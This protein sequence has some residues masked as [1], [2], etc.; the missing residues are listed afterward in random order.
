MHNLTLLVFLDILPEAIIDIKRKFMKHLL[1]FSIGLISLISSYYLNVESMKKS[2]K[3]IYSFLSS[4]S[5]GKIYG[6]LEEYLSLQ[7][8]NLSFLSVSNIVA[9]DE[10]GENL[11]S[12]KKN[13]SYTF[14]RSNEINYSSSHLLINIKNSDMPIRISKIKYSMSDS[15]WVYYL[16][17]FLINVLLVVFLLV[18]KKR[19]NATEH[20]YIEDKFL[21][22]LASVSTISEFCNLNYSE[23]RK[24]QDKVMQIYFDNDKRL[25]WKIETLEAELSLLES[26]RNSGSFL[27]ESEEESIKKSRAE[28]VKSIYTLTVLCERLSE[29]GLDK[30]DRVLIDAIKSSA[31][32]CNSVMSISEILKS[33]NSTHQST[34]LNVI[35]EIN[36][37]IS[38]CH[39][40]SLKK[41]ISLNY[42]PN[43][44]LC[45][46]KH[47]Y[48]KSISFIL[49][50]LLKEM[51]YLTS[52]NS[53]IDIRTIMTE[54][55]DLDHIQFKFSVIGGNNEIVNNK[56]LRFGLIK[57]ISEKYGDYFSISSIKNDFDGTFDTEIIYET[58]CHMS[59]FK[60]KVIEI[61]KDASIAV[62][63]K[64]I[65]N[66][67]RISSQIRSLGYKVDEINSLK[68]IK[69]YSLIFISDYSIDKK[70]HL[71]L[72][73]RG[74]D[75]CSIEREI[76]D[77]LMKIKKNS[78]GISFV[79]SYC[80]SLIDYK[81]VIEDSRAN[82]KNDFSS[83][84]SDIGIEKN[85]LPDAIRELLGTTRKLDKITILSNDFSFKSSLSA[86]LESSDIFE[87]I[88]LSIDSVSKIDLL[89]ENSVDIIIIEDDFLIEGSK[90]DVNNF[91]EKL[92]YN[93]FVIGLCED[94]S[95]E[96]DIYDNTVY[97]K[98]NNLINEIT[99][100]AETRTAGIKNGGNVV[101]INFTRK[102]I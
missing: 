60:S 47:G 96:D 5:D 12:G 39:E 98:S 14:I 38:S 68:D 58:K 33:E 88:D 50:F 62:Y 57:S 92:N 7:I 20:T 66:S 70:D 59:L 86:I 43:E 85:I 41:D 87:F 1:L 23:L 102:N 78:L 95:S 44:N 46:E 18:Y 25:S 67:K 63:D 90:L 91:K 64:D 71:Y 21:D 54:K 9:F 79:L 94:S 6:S 76:S 48:G 15:G 81:E 83:Y 55:N 101:N 51:I 93:C 52:N 4:S 34:N 26:Q 28:L 17:S 89:K 56:K 75:I 22:N 42:Y 8:N 99:F 36:Y 40:L 73:G 16:A 65:N 61:D 31:K 84:V 80:S 10:N 97:K 29:V 32:N 49:D 35:N 72:S 30:K 11:L 53:S 100:I 77:D 3:F 24:I 45:N 2:D 74:I 82:K 13:K 37:I 27:S 69:H 19:H